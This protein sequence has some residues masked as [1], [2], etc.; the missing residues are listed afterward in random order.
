M[1]LIPHLLGIGITV[2]IGQLLMTTAYKADHAAVVAAATYV[3]PIWAVIGDL[4][5]FAALPEL[6]GWIGGAI[7][8]AA[9]LGILM[10]KPRELATKT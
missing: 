1:S 9:G 2:T 6:N 8:I 7:V 10:S 4:I 5:L 3:S